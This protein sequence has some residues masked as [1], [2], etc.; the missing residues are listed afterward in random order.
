MYHPKFN[1]GDVIELDLH[2]EM[3]HSYIGDSDELEFLKGFGIIPGK[4]YVVSEFIEK[5]DFEYYYLVM[6]EGVELAWA[7]SRFK[8]AEPLILEN[9]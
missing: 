1:V 8:L 4:H 6:M 9:E 7:S 5:F 2:S 3:N